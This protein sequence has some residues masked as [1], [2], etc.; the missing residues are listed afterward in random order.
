MLRWTAVSD[1]NPNYTQLADTIQLT[2]FAVSK[3]HSRTRLISWPRVQNDAMPDPPHTYLPYPSLFEATQVSDHAMSAFYLDIANM[4][5]H[6]TL[7]DWLAKLFPLKP[8]R[9]Q[10]LDEKTLQR[11]RR[12]LP[13]LDTSTNPIL[14]PCQATMPM[15]L[16]MGGVYCT[17]FRSGLYRLRIQSLQK[18]KVCTSGHPKPEQYA[19]TKSTI[20]R[21]TNQTTRAQY[22]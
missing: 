1:E 11:I 2:S 10:E 19:R 16:Q 4:F 18:F 6:I 5:N 15:R 20:P 7:P 3:M 8:I 21:D 22:H 13:H 14:R 17:L 12:Q 9:A